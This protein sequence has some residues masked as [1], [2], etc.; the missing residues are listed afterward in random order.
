M[1]NTTLSPRQQANRLKLAIEREQFDDH[2]EGLH[3]GIDATADCIRCRVD[4][5]EHDQVAMIVGNAA[6]AERREMA[7][8]YFTA[9]NRARV[10]FND[11]L[12]TDVIALEHGATL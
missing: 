8:A 9:T 2:R 5:P 7:R 6:T 11:E 1:T 3:I 12:L 10:G 4:G